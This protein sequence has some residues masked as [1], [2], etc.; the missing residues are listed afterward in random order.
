MN[1][2]T[3][4]IFAG[5]TVLLL[6]P[7]AGLLAV[8]TRPTKPN[9]ILIL[10]DDLGYGDAGCYGGSLAATPAID[11]LARTGVRCT[12]GYVTAPVCAPSRCGIMTGSYNQRFGIQWND[13]RAKYN[14]GQHK[15]LPQALRAAGYVTGHIGKWNV[16]ADIEGCFDETYDVIDWEA[17]YFPDKIGHYVG[18]DSQTEH[19]SSKVQGVWGARSPR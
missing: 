12:D 1:E 15:L 14:V 9:L 17:D 3:S 7:L 4:R 13:D 10:A 8:E 5:F 18:V 11:S 19:A 2:T 16:G 6:S